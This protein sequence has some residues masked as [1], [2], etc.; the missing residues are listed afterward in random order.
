MGAVLQG[1]AGLI[2]L[3]VTTGVAIMVIMAYNDG[4]ATVAQ[5]ERFASSW[6]QNWNG[7]LVFYGA[8]FLL[9]LFVSIPAF[10]LIGEAETNE[11]QEQMKQRLGKLE[12]S[13]K[14]QQQ[15]ETE[16]VSLL[17]DIRDQTRKSSV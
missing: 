7:D 16:M 10:R 12:A 17:R 14:E 3:V 1:L 2:Y 8:L 4:A 15:R 6:I 11:W 5:I 9:W 13:H